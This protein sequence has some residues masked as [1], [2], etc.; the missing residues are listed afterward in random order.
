MVCRTVGLFVL[1]ALA[2]AAVPAA[3]AAQFALR[4]VSFSGGTSIRLSAI[5][6]NGIIGGTYVDTGGTYNGFLLKGQALTI[7]PNQDIYG[8][9]SVPTPSSILSDGTA[10]GSLYYG[11]YDGFV[12]QNG[13]F[14]Q[15][16]N[17]GEDFDDP[18]VQIN[19]S[20]VVTYN[21]LGYGQQRLAF[22][23]V[24]PNFTQIAH[25]T[26]QN[27]IVSSINRSGEIAGIVQTYQFS[28][29]SAFIING[30]RYRLLAPPGG[31]STGGIINN[32][33][34]VAGA[35][36]DKSGVTRGFIWDR[37]TYTVFTAP[38]TVTAMTIGAFSATGYVAGTYTDTANVQHG[39][40]YHN[41]FFNSFGKEPL[42]QYDISVVGITDDGHVAVNEFG[43]QDTILPFIAICKD[44][45]C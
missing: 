27:P 15:I 23:G 39:F 3:N 33:H 35:Y 25:N 21:V 40:L 41:G 13:G 37:G 36:L 18:H 26:W 8:S 34:Q 20:G 24:P 1:S 17:V 4:A 9:A 28:P 6:P 12:W 31:I 11:D 16:F 5:S 43:S 38:V 22:V 32:K 19:A 7:L 29:T 45:D 14:T 42:A 30:S 10:A 44:A 2:V